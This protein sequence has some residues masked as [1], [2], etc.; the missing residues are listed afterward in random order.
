MLEERYSTLINKNQLTDQN[1]L[2]NHKKLQTEIKSINMELTE[3]KSEIAHIKETNTLII[4]DLRECARRED[5]EVL[6]KYLKLWE[7]VR[8]VT[9]N[10]VENIVMDII[11][12]LGLDKKE[13]SPKDS[14]K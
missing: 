7:P 3:M 9:Q 13:D 8:F 2:A 6:E 12:N 14:K 11:E 4:Q 10:Q 5:V 1:M